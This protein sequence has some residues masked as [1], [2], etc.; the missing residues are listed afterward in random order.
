[1]DVGHFITSPRDLVN[2]ASISPRAM[3]A[4]A[5]LARYPCVLTR[6]TFRLVDVVGSSPLIPET[7]EITDEESSWD[8]YHQLGRAK[9]AAVEWSSCKRGVLSHIF[10]WFLNV[11][12]ECH[13]NLI[14]I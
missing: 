3:S 4:A 11:V 2:L 14:S 10:P 12:L 5:D 13:T 8:Y 9:F 7:T 6:L 1:M